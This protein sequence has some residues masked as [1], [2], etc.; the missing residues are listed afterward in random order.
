MRSLGQA[1]QSKRRMGL[2]DLL[3]Q[4][5]D[6]ITKEGLIG[7]F[8]A[9]L[10]LVKLGVVTA[11]QTDRHDEIEVTLCEKSEGDLDELMR[12]SRFMD[13]EP[14]EEEAIPSTP[15]QDLD[16]TQIEVEDLSGAQAASEEDSAPGEPVAAEPEPALEDVHDGTDWPR[17]I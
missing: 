6:E 11:F 13:E 2:R 14:E 5:D 3:T 17:Q 10:E 7:A 16:S 12:V 8:C 4:F 1:I 9:L 15:D